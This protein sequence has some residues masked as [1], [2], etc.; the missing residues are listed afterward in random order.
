MADSSSTFPAL[1]VLGGEQ[2]GVQFTIEEAVDNILLGSDPSC[3]F[4]LAMPGV[5]PVHARIWVDENGITLY[6]TH[7]P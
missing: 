1:T 6:D 7:S 5:S 3:R 2:A 4:C